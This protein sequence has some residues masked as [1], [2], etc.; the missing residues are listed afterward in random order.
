MSIW[1]RWT[2]EPHRRKRLLSS[3]DRRPLGSTPGGFWFPEV[4]SVVVCV[5]ALQVRSAAPFR[6][7]CGVCCE[8][9][10]PRMRGATAHLCGVSRGA[11]PKCVAYRATVDTGR[12]RVP[13]PGD[14]VRALTLLAAHADTVDPPRSRPGASWCQAR[15]FAEPSGTTP[16]SCIARPRRDNRDSNQF[17]C[18]RFRAHRPR[19]AAA[20]RARSGRGLIHG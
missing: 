6:D 19:R 1:F 5:G 15:S 7:G 16:G 4:Y 13:E 8:H 2:W 17:S 14:D 9:F 12:P 10:V 18:R 11:G 3:M 20:P